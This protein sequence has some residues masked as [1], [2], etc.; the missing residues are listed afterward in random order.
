M[1][2]VKDRS[3]V[4]PQ[5]DFDQDRI[6][7]FMLDPDT[8]DGASVEHIE[9]HI[10]HVFLAGEHAYKMK[11]AVVLPFVDF[12]SKTA[13]LKACH[14]EIEV[15][16]RT[17]PD[18]YLDVLTISAF[19]GSLSLGGPGEPVDF[20][21]RMRRFRQDCL[22]DRI[23]AEHRLTPPLVHG[24]ADQVAALH[25]AADRHLPGT[26][27]EDFEKTATDLLRRLNDTDCSD[28]TRARLHVLEKLILG[29][30]H[31]QIPEIRARARHGAVRHGHGDLHLG[32]LCVFNESIRLFD[33]IEFEPRFSHID[34]LYDIAFV[35][36][37]LLHRACNAEAITMLSR[38]LS[39]TRDYAGVDNLRLFMAV[40]AG[41][42][43]LVALLANA[44][45]REAQAQEFI[46]LAIDIL[47]R[48]R[49]RRL[50]AVGGRSGTGKSTLALSLAP[51]LATA[52]DVIVLRADE[53]RKRMFDT[54]P[55]D[56]LPASA[57]SDSV[58]TQVYRRLFRDAARTVRNGDPRRLVPRVTEPIGI[59]GA[60]T[61]TWCSRDRPL[62][63][64]THRGA[65][66]PLVSAS[67]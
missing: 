66:Q 27:S 19:E 40:R 47:D 5:P 6:V 58:T 12:S 53:L 31:D 11:K 8:H 14:G 54:P 42:R 3:H 64:R 52:P 17:A 60:G 62:A 29:A 22:L 15:N 13:R 18:I 28:V 38:Y 49:T 44:S 33:A 25:L 48:P 41:V 23:A 56:P 30:L 65:G 2:D 36:M 61:Q 59:P 39:A 50:I 63:V 43:A 1:S 16:R 32:N 34:V 7:E 35:T 24:I 67:A 45:G 55:E 51:V 4:P 9:T 21:V 20:V 26:L 37:D 57:Y 46:E 10:S